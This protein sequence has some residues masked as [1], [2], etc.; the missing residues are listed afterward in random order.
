MKP[1]AL[2]ATKWE[3]PLEEQEGVEEEQEAVACIGLKKW[4]LNRGGLF[5]PHYLWMG[6]G[7]D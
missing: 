2:V 6:K 3:N 7:G 5:R 4:S 1:A